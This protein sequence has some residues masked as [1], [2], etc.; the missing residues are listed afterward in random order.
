MEELMKADIFFFITSIAVI[1]VT[2][3]VIIALNYIVRI[4]RNVR[5]ISERV[6]EGTKALSED[7][8]V[9]RGNLKTGGFAWKHIFGFLGKHS[10]WFTRSTRN[11]HSK[12]SGGV[13]TGTDSS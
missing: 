4:L 8:T 11:R 12:T 7:L 10:R 3:G 5:D 13:D 1:L 9:L 2:V 6:D